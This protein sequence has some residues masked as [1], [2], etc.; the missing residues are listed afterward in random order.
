MTNALDQ[1]SLLFDASWQK[2]GNKAYS[3]LPK[4]GSG[5]LTVTRLGFASIRNAA[6]QIEIVPE[7]TARI[8]YSNGALPELLLEPEGIMRG[9]SANF[10]H[11]EV[12]GVE[13]EVSGIEVIVGQPA[14][15]IVENTAN[16]IHG[17]VMPL[18]SFVNG[19]KH[20]ISFLYKRYS[21]IGGSQRSLKIVLSNG[22]TGELELNTTTHEW[23]NSS[24]GNI[25]SVIN[26]I[27]Y[28][29]DFYRAAVVVDSDSSE[30][31]V[32]I[33]MSSDDPEQL[34]NAYTGDGIS[35]IYLTG[36]NLVEGEILSS[37]IPKYDN[38]NDTTVTRSADQLV[39]SE[40]ITNGILSSLAGSLVLEIRYP[41]T[42]N[43]NL[44]QLCDSDQTF[45]IASNADKVL[46]VS[47]GASEQS[48]SI[49]TENYNGVLVITWQ[50][51]SLKVYQNNA[52]LSTLNFYSA[53][54]L[55]QIRLLGK[56]APAHLRLLGVYRFALEEETAKAIS[57][58]EL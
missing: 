2:E 23:L 47:G 58:L 53:A 3:V 6:G 55:D 15:K 57:N 52:L 36:Y 41:L 24:D 18:E 20:V 40:L 7:D 54:D 27:Q 28:A 30:A 56:Q 38:D 43:A 11:W 48:A 14:T 49:G 50:G 34:D 37:Y 13:R 1:V 12:E 26:G 9:A 19:G 10:M 45:K 44:W 33:L 35:G 42:N 22:L 46:A 51:D 17:L 31:D 16:S 8:D 32:S 39:V 29:D 5:D 25:E 4:S 21:P